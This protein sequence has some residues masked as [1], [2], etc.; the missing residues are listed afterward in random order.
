MF[1]HQTIKNL[2]CLFKKIKFETS[3]GFFHLDVIK[4]YKNL[5]I[6]KLVIIAIEFFVFKNI[7]DLR[8]LNKDYHKYLDTGK[9]SLYSKE[10]YFLYL[11][12]NLGIL[13]FPNNQS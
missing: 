7:K 3:K 13:V 4:I 12:T 8:K 5:K 6:P 11:R 2:T 9:I 1:S 10:F